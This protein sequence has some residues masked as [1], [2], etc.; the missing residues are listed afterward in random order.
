MTESQLENILSKH[1]KKGA[2]CIHDGDSMYHPIIVTNAIKNI[3]G[4]VRSN[5]SKYILN[6]IDDHSQSLK[7]R[8]EDK[9][10]LNKI[11]KKEI[12]LTVFISDLEDA[13]QNGDINTTQ[14]HLSRLYLASDGSP[15]I[16]QNLAELALQDIDE[17]GTFIYHCLRAFAFEPEKDRV[18]VF[19]Q[20]IIRTLLNKG[21]PR[22]HSGVNINVLDINKYFLSINDSKGMNTLCSVWR[23]LESEYTRLPGFKRE[24]S[25]WINQ[26]NISN[27]I[28][29]EEKNPDNLNYYIENKSDYFVKLTEDIIQSNVHINERITTL[30]SLRYFTKKIDSKYLPIVAYKI[31]LLMDNYENR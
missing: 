9:K 29:I 15:A 3:L 11:N 2:S 23:L 12:G 10:Y 8:I 16:L 4:D 31:Y 20:C 1:L 6:F 25:F 19:L 26:Y 5:P 27:T 17:Y 7:M 30:E 21:L 18:W 13:C 14:K 24:I 22:P 28:D